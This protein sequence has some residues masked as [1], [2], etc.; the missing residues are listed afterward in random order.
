MAYMIPNGIRVPGGV[1]RFLRRAH[2][3]SASLRGSRV[4]VGMGSGP[5]YETKWEQGAGW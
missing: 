4:P 1:R 2:S 5:Q 3:I